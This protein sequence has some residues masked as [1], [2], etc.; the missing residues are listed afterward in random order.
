MLM[1]STNNRVNVKGTSP[2][3]SQIP[4]ILRG[5]CRRALYKPFGLEFRAERFRFPDE[6][7]VFNL[8]GV[9]KRM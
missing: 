7:A 9:H 8:P 5:A 4:G 6:I 2:V 1:I 3:L